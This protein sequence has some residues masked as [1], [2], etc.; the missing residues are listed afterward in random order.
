MAEYNQYQKLIKCYFGE[1]IEPA[2]YKKGN[3][4][5]TKD[6]NS[7]EECEG[8]ATTSENNEDETVDNG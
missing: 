2:E 4:I 7:L 8:T 5:Q 3:L 6:F 1:P